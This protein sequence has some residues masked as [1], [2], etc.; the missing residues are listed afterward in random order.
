[1]IIQKRKQQQ[2]ISGK[3]QDEEKK[4]WDSSNIF[5][6]LGLLIIGIAAIAILLIL[7]SFYSYEKRAGERRLV[8]DG[9]SLC[10]LIADLIQH[11][12]QM[13]T[14]KRNLNLLDYV[15]R[16][17]GIVYC[18]AEDAEGETLVRLG[19][20]MPE[21]GCKFKAENNQQAEHLLTQKRLEN[22][23]GEVIYEFSK[24]IYREGKRAGLVKI[25]LA[26]SDY[27]HFNQ[28]I[29]FLFGG[30]ALSIFGLV[31][32]F[33]YLLKRLFSPLHQINCQLKRIIT[34]EEEFPK[35][36]ISFRGEIGQIA[37]QLNHVLSTQNMRSR[38]QEE[39][40]A[41]LEISNKVLL[42][43][44]IRL[45]AILD[46]LN[47]GIIV[48]DTTGRTILAN[49]LAGHF[50]REELQDYLGKPWKDFLHDHEPDL[51][52][53]F[54]RFYDKGNIYGHDSV[55]IQKN[56]GSNLAIFHHTCSYLLNG[57]D[58]PLGFLWMIS[59]ITSQKQS[60]LSKYEFVNHVAHELKTP[61]NT[62][63]SYSEMLL[64]GEVN[65]EQT[66]REFFNSINEEAIRLSRLINNLLNISKIEM[67][68]LKIN[69]TLI[70]VDKLLR[71]CYQTVRAQALNKGID[72]T[73][74]LADKM[75]NLLL[76][77]D[78]IE[79]AILNLLTNAIK[80]TPAMGKVTL[81]GIV[82]EESVL[83]RVTDSGYGIPEDE[84]NHIFDKFFRSSKEEIKKEQ[85]NGLGLSLAMNIVQLHKGDIKV[86]SKWGS[87]S[88]FTIILPKEEVY[89]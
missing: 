67:G 3:F 58:S 10:S 52:P 29:G 47:I 64:E 62:L 4:T 75:P 46:N 9:F 55:E 84:L 57:E 32:L 18:L 82:E 40:N 66:K 7:F 15:V 73:M 53:V 79:V 26:L 70:K 13:E 34:G 59:D 33:Y 1:M 86:E 35:I 51:V 45:R 61:L 43:E 77:K 48:I 78:L 8:K 54:T 76:D 80:Y 23:N 20:Q 72:F 17:K 21:E 24:P 27:I 81:Q 49:K 56:E 60:E 71:D 63:V 85:G 31:F 41:E 19:R 87:G 5:N 69:R 89:I 44:K 11:E 6:R 36:E 88:S 14:Q 74:D 12:F 28:E 2:E 38:R 50:L 16:E 30:I 65:D 42:Y 68:C 83:I 25:G 37:Q 39:I 22:Q